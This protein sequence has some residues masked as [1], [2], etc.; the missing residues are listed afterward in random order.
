MALDNVTLLRI[1]NLHPKLRVEALEIYTKITHALTGRAICRF[2]FTLRTFQE[3]AALYAQG[4]TKFYDSLGNKLKIVTN[5]KAGQSLHNYGLAVDIAL[6]KDKDCN[7]TFETSSWEDTVDF[8]GDGIA[9]WMECV[10]LFKEYGWAW[11]GDW[12]SIKDK[13]HFEKT[14]GLGWRELFKRHQNGLV[15]ENG[16]VKI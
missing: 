1:N 10:R 11:G 16:F 5:A 2:A 13:P 3:Q 9:D 4:R 7:G 8:D 14:F 12:K 15:D 6:I